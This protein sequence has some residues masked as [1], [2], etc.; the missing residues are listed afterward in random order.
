M[1]TLAHALTHTG[2]SCAAIHSERVQTTAAARLSRPKESIAGQRGAVMRRA[3]LQ[4]AVLTAALTTQREEWCLHMMLC[5][6]WGLCCALLP[7]ICASEVQVGVC[8]C[9]HA[10]M[11]FLYV[12]SYLTPFSKILNWTETVLH[13]SV[14]R[15]T[16]QPWLA[17]AASHLSCY[18]SF[19]H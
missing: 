4:A 19:Y 7:S 1:R 8:V 11:L 17:G 2:W 12:R 14:H 18:W 3:F 16:L 10:C 15:W 9:V 6:V 5:L 13:F